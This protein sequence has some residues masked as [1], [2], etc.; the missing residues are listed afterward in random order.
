M[1]LEVPTVFDPLGGRDQQ[2]VVRWLTIEVS[3]FSCP[4]S[5]I[6]PSEMEET[7][8]EAVLIIFVRVVLLDLRWNRSS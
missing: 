6:R 2:V 7:K 3:V 1:L 4:V 8:G 5:S